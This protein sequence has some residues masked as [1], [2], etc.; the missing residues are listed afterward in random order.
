MQKVPNM[1]Y[2]C[3]KTESRVLAMMGAIDVLYHYANFCLY[4]FSAYK[5]ALAN[6]QL[7]L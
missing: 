7:V 6:K 3:I 2:N 4:A 5:I 1:N